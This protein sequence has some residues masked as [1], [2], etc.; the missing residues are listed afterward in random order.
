MRLFPEDIEYLYQQ[1]EIGLRVR[2]VNQ[3]FLFGWQDGDL[4][5]EAHAPLQEDE[6]DWH[7]NVLMHARSSLVSYKGDRNQLD[8]NRV[9]RIADDRRGFPISVFSGRP[10]TESAVRN[11]RPVFNVVSSDGVVQRIADERIN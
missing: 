11:A 2:I 4:V 10:D 5:L 8:E 6:R 3:P 1:A 9:L 7:G